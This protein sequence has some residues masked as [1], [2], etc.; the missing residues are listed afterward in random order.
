MRKF[1][2]QS[3]V[4]SAPLVLLAA[5]PAGA[6]VSASYGAAAASTPTFF[7]K[8]TNSCT[9]NCMVGSATFTPTGTVTTTVQM[10][11]YLYRYK[12]ATQSAPVCT[13]GSSCSDTFLV[14]SSKL[15]STTSGNK[16]A[17]TLSVSTS[18]STVQSA[19]TGYYVRVAFS[20]GNGVSYAESSPVLKV[21]GC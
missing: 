6:T 14:S 7:S 11:V 4:M 3:V 17:T 18:C 15:F 5:N 8:P 16:L 12:S 20:S 13:T 9:S 2:Q 19:V 10:F 21:K 1:T